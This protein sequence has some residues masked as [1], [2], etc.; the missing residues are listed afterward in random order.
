MDAKHLIVLA[1]QVSIFCVVFGFGLKTSAGDLLSVVRRPK[2]LARS[3]LSVFVLMPIVTVLLV[4]ALD[5]RPEVRGILVALAISPMPPILPQKEAKAGGDSSFAL[6]LMAVLALVAIAAAPASLALL[7]LLFG[8]PAGVAP[9]A[10]A[11]IA[12]ISILVPLGTGVMIRFIQA[13]FARH[14]EKWVTRFGWVLLSLGALVL[15]AGSLSAIWAHAGSLTLVAIVL[16]TMSGLLIGHLLGGPN[17]EEATVLAF[18]TAC[19]HPA[20]AVAI[21]TAN[22]PEYSFAAPVMLYLLVSG[23]VGLPYS[24]WQRR[25]TRMASA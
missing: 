16:F 11:K 15:L 13:D 21:A 23:V 17:R 1:L 7:G 19:R 25:T 24:S 3:L 20:I 12:M 14:L 8:R 6:G 2:L 9:A 18:S 5:L 22:F 10:V 4:R